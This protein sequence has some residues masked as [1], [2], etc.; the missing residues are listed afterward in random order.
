MSSSTLPIDCEQ[1]Q[2]SIRAAVAGDLSNTKRMDLR[3]HAQACESCRSEFAGSMQ[4][5]AALGH[6]KRLNR[7]VEEKAMRRFEQKRCIEALSTPKKLSNGRLRTLLYP[8]FFAI[9]ML[10]L[11]GNLPFSSG[12]RVTAQSPGVWIRGHELAVDAGEAR[13]K[14]GEVVHTLGGGHALIS[15]GETLWRTLGKSAIRLEGTK[16]PTMR[17]AQGHLEL[18][19]AGRCLT[20]FGIVV[21][22]EHCWVTMEMS[23][24][25]LHI[26]VE[27][28]E[29]LFMTA[30]GETPLQAGQSWHAGLDG[31][32]A[33]E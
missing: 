23:D 25:G 11:A 27:E 3:R 30:S 7:V 15:V 24:S 26:E 13:I 33:Q 9:L 14:R 12:P 19:G 4:T 5:L 10:A 8:A 20:E 21:G 16:N 17:L 32:V 18:Q 31:L 29:A 2:V 6:E 1:A 28:G 22:Q